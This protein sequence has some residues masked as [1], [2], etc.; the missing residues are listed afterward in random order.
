MASKRFA[1]ALLTL[2]MVFSLTACSKK[3]EETKKSEKTTEKQ[4]ETEKEPDDTTTKATTSEESSEDTSK[5]NAGIADDQ[6]SLNKTT[7][8]PGCI[9]IIPE[10]CDAIWGLAL[11]SPSS[12]DSEMNALR[13][14][15]SNIRYVFE[16]MDHLEIYPKM[17]FSGKAEAYLVPHHEDASIYTADYIK[18]LPAEVERTVLE[19][20]N[21]PNWYWGQLTLNEEVYAP[22]YY[23]LLIVEDNEPLASVCLKIVSC[24]ELSDVSL[25]DYFSMLKEEMDKTGGQ[26]KY[27]I[28]FDKFY[29]CYE[30]GIWPDE[31]TWS[32]S[33]LPTIP[34]VCTDA[35]IEMEV[36]NTTRV[37]IISSLEDYDGEQACQ[38][39]DEVFRNNGYEITYPDGDADANYRYVY[40]DI[41]G[42]PAELSYYSYNGEL[43]F[44]IQ[45]LVANAAS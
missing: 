19:D 35:T 26:E 23:D 42:V 27:K 32:G 11:A 43:H 29:G 9:E 4:E 22:G 36:N 14:R 40:T 20:P 24:G 16:N 44:S 15:Y 30:Q 18:S 7:H 5:A 6:A 3:S 34:S 33:D 45:N 12:G 21:D 2:A 39:I 1:A 41:D 31:Y 37:H 28:D 38:D 8:T 25:Y 17:G 10:S 13:Y